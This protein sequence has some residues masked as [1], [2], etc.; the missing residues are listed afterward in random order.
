MT[1][2]KRSSVTLSLPVKIAGIDH[3]LPAGD[4]E[5]VAD[6]ELIE[7]LSFPAYRRTATWIMARS[8]SGHTEMLAVDPAA[9]NAAI[10]CDRA[11]NPRV[12]HE[13]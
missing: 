1:R 3:V 5:I 4:Y 11:L 9:L 2:T 7:G 13:S 10:N 8:S 6:E 12:R